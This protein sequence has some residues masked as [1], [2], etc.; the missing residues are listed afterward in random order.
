MSPRERQP[1]QTSGKSD[2]REDP[3]AGRRPWIRVDGADL[4]PDP[5]REGHYDVR[6]RGHN[7]RM[8]I[9]PPRIEIGG[10]AL[11]DLS[12]AEDG[13]AIRGTLARK[14]ENDQVIVDYGFARDEAKT[15]FQEDATAR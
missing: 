14:P 12:F 2:E 5:D 15:T 3:M 11:R 10:V 1:K 13:T 7:L 4:R 6:I 8:A 9:S